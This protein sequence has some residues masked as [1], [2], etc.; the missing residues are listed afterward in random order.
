MAVPW[1]I[2]PTFDEAENIEAILRAAATTG[3]TFS[4][5]SY[6]GRISQAAPVTGGL[7]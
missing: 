3:S 4:A 5:S 2:L 1:L 7:Q 6:V